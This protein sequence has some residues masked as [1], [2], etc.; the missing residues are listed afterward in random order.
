MSSDS[1]PVPVNIMGKEYLIACPDD[2]RDELLASAD[3]LNRRMKKIRDSGKVAG[4]ERVAVM[5]ALNLTHELLK[6]QS[7]EKLH[8]PRKRLRALQDR[9]DAAL[10]KVAGEG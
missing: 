10:E 4:L 7:S 6:Y 5:A 8:A 9:I 2:Q 3:E 1:N